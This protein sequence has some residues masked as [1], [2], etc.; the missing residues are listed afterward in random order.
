[1]KKVEVA[2][3]FFALFLIIPPFLISQE[4]NCTVTIHT[5]SIQSAQLGY[6]RTFSQDIE[7][8]M[9]NTRFTNEES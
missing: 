8:Y 1:M 3:L 4:L 7:R 6:L 2:V 5:E 9:N